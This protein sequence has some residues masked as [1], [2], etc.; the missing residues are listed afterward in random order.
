MDRLSRAISI[1]VDLIN[2]KIVDTTYLSNKYEV[3]TRTIYRD[4]EL[5][6]LSGIPIIS[7]RGK[8]GGFSINDKC[9]R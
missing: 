7:E 1:M 4:I 3:S 8:N 2:K 9:N 5:L 6:N